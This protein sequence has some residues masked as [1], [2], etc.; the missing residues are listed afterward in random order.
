MLKFYL[1]Y[2]LGAILSDF[3]GPGQVISSGCI[4]G[5]IKAYWQWLWKE[6]HW[7]PQI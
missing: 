3:D 5:C 1:S 7:A 6:L 2:R 4:T